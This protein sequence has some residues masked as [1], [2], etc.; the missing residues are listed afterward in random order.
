METRRTIIL[1]DAAQFRSKN[2]FEGEIISQP[3]AESQ[4][5]EYFELNLPQ[6]GLKGSYANAQTK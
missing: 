6:N 3:I 4:K 1:T 2:Q 5:D